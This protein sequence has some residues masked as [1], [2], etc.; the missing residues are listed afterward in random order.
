VLGGIGELDVLLGR[1]DG[2]ER[3]SLAGISSASSRRTRTARRASTT[4][5]GALTPPEM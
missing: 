4:W 3:S 1:A 5:L 2:R